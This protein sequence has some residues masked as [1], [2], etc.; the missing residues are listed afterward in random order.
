MGDKTNA[1]MSACQIN[2]NFISGN[3][4]I[5]KKKKEEFVNKLRKN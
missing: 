2:K 1:K 3:R 5:L 4:I